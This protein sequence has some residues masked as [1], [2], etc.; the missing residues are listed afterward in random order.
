MAGSVT[1]YQPSVLEQQ[2]SCDP[3]K[4]QTVSCH[5]AATDET[6]GIN[7]GVDGKITAPSETAIK[8]ASVFETPNESSVHLDCND[9]GAK[10]NLQLKHAVNDK[11]AN[12][13]ISQAKKDDVTVKKHEAASSEDSK[14]ENEAQ[15]SNV[16]IGA[17][18]SFGLK[19]NATTSVGNK[20]KLAEKIPVI[21]TNSHRLLS[22]K[23]KSGDSTQGS[24]PSVSSPS[25]HTIDKLMNRAVDIVDASEYPESPTCPKPEFIDNESLDH[26]DAVA[27]NY[28]SGASNFSRRSQGN[29][30][31]EK[32]VER[33]MQPV[34]LESSR[35]QEGLCCSSSSGKL[36]K[37]YGSI[38]SPE[39]PTGSSI[40]SSPED[41]N[42]PTASS[43]TEV[44]DDGG[45]VGGAG[46]SEVQDE[47][48]KKK[49][50]RK[51]KKKGNAEADPAGT[52]NSSDHE[53]KGLTSPGTSGAEDSNKI[54]EPVSQPLPKLKT[55]PPPTNGPSG[56]PSK[57]SALPTKTKKA[58]NKNEKKQTNNAKKQVESSVEDS[59]P[60]SKSISS[61]K[62]DRPKSLDMS[63]KDDALRTTYESSSDKKLS[64]DKA[65]KLDGDRCAAKEDNA[66]DINS[67]SGNDAEKSSEDTS[68]K[69]SQESSM[70]ENFRDEDESNENEW[71]TYGIKKSKRR[72][73]AAED[74]YS[75]RPSPADN[76]RRSY[77]SGP[78]DPKLRKSSSEPSGMS[79]WMDVSD[80]RPVHRHASF[81]RHHNLREEF[82]SYSRKADNLP[83]DEIV[84]KPPPPVSA[85]S[86][87][88]KLKAKPPVPPSASGRKS[89]E[90][91]P[92]VGDHQESK[93]EDGKTVSVSL[94]SGATDIGEQQ[95]DPPL[96][97]PPEAKDNFETKSS[98]SSTTGE[99]DS[100]T[101]LSE[102]P[103]KAY[104]SSA[105][106]AATAAKSASLPRDMGRIPDAE[107]PKQDNTSADNVVQYL[108]LQCSNDTY[109]ARLKQS[110]NKST[111]D[112]KTPSK[113]LSTQQETS[114]ASDDVKPARTSKL[115]ISHKAVSL[116]SAPPAQ[117][118]VPKKS[119]SANSKDKDSMRTVKS[120][121]SLNLTSEGTPVIQDNSFPFEAEPAESFDITFGSV[122]FCESDFELIDDVTQSNQQQKGKSDSKPVPR[123]SPV[124]NH[125]NRT[126]ASSPSPPNQVSCADLE[127]AWIAK[128][129]QNNDKNDNH[130]DRKTTP[131]STS[132]VPS[133]PASLAAILASG[134]K[135]NTPHATVGENNNLKKKPLDQQQYWA[136]RFNHSELADMLL[137][138]WEKLNF[139][140]T[141]QSSK[142]VVYEEE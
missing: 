119:S 10:S 17:S 33:E 83:A 46:G 4:A 61:I 111:T 74:R 138:E 136:A 26:A 31:I 71:Q 6:V 81:S 112:T 103:A 100:Q 82:H 36:P 131:D 105:V 124:N 8:S 7:A 12:N 21:N 118:V 55:Q 127:K 43:T 19:R 130:H 134:N 51:K 59:K 90:S 22:T 52:A 39:P 48:T 110:I 141:K 66:S 107:L 16:D 28:V 137:K 70:D 86:Y 69:A 20:P 35:E 101:D 68:V 27:L 76:L 24:K 106:S 142:V 128:S 116:D 13:L 9:V 42:S 47:P 135:N 84:E 133:V 73:L 53:N 1:D 67:E 120:E 44:R 125:E 89:Q 108:D 75:L 96:I 126:S 11:G 117:A 91:Q 45:G 72:A 85:N 41:E 25:P 78:F 29:N 32:P 34:K 123:P 57:T 102:I 79:K 94:D 2:Q 88:A 23:N 132:T 77:Y 97:K 104:S 18:I 38:D 56:A 92:V 5:M 14:V 99:L 115:E 95:E 50:K 3:P 62:P 80:N 113:V 87:A 93:A 64:N 139:E 109:A 58:E 129:P 60:V 49:R 63:D 98:T 15:H 65:V 40:I 37:N 122:K 121:T 54:T 140:L 30:A 114:K